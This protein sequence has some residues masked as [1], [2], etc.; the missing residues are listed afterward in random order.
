[1]ADERVKRSQLKLKIQNATHRHKQLSSGLDVAEPPPRT[2]QSAE[3]AILQLGLIGEQGELPKNRTD[4]IGSD[5][6]GA[7]SASSSVPRFSDSPNSR[8]HRAKTVSGHL[9]SGKPGSRPTHL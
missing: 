4:L 2:H 7:L 1:M 3:D 9:A 8:Q 6:K 5:Q